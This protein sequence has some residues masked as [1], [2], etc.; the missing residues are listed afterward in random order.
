MTGRQEN[1]G[2]M[3]RRSFIKVTALASGALLIGVGCREPSTTDVEAVAQEPWEANL[4]VRID[5]D[6]K[7]TIISKNPEGGQGVKTAFP[8]VVA[9]CLEVDWHDVQMAARPWAA[10][11]A[12]RTAG[13][14]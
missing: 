1:F 12:L 2:N 4:Y 6:G 14:T 10:A 13:M 11:A 9:E 8:M 5:P 3:D 7:V